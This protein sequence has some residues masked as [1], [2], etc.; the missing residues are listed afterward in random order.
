MLLNKSLVME[1]LKIKF[2]SGR[3]VDISLGWFIFI[4]ALFIA[5]ALIIF[6]ILPLTKIYTEAIKIWRDIKQ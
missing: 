4:M 6:D 2:K 1:N 5:G 3:E